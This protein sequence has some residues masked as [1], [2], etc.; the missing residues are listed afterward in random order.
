M[1]FSGLSPS[2]FFFQQGYKFS[3]IACLII[4]VKKNFHFFDSLSKPKQFCPPMASIISSMVARSGSVM[5]DWQKSS[6]CLPRFVNR[7]ITSWYHAKVTLMQP[8]F[9]LL[10]LVYVHVL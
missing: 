1:T 4:H 10:S 2:S 9:V 7:V 3:E 6:P 8:F 5:G